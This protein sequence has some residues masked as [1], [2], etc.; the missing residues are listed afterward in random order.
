MFYLLEACKHDRFAS[1]MLGVF[2][3]H[4]FSIYSSLLVS[5]KYNEGGD[6]STVLRKY[7][8]S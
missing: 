3:V 2:M 6:I 7:V 1:F 5:E 8:F 4:I